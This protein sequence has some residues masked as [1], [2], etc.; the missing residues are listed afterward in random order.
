MKY[1]ALLLSLLLA[2]PALA[3]ELTFA[4]DPNP[5]PDVIGYRLHFGDSSG[6]YTRTVNVGSVTSF[7]EDVDW[8]TETKTGT[9]RYVIVTAYNAAGLESPP[10]NELD[11]GS[12][13][14]SAP[15]NPRRIPD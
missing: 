4:W 1:A 11:L 12:A 3:E 15:K 13:A 2:L 7:T 10:S 9:E 5:E 14:P 6:N 8:D